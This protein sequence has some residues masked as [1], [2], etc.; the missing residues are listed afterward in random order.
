MK[1][2]LLSDLHI[3]FWPTAAKFHLAMFDSFQTDADVL[4]LAG[5]INVGRANTLSTLKEFAKRYKHVIYVMGNHEEYGQE[6]G[7]FWDYEKFV[8]KLPENVY[9][10]DVRDFI[11]VDGVF[12]FGSCLYTNFGNDPLAENMAR[13]GI[14][15][16]Q[17]IKGS[18]TADYIAE[19]ES[20][21]SG[22]KDCYNLASDY[23]KVIVTHF[24]PAMECISE[25]FHTGGN[26]GINKYYANNLGNY[27]A[28]LKDTTWLFGHTH[29]SIDMFIGDTRMLCNPMGYFGHEMN[30]NFNPKAKSLTFF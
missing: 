12:F 14:N 16:F 11:I 20:A 4:V 3:E 18:S 13:Y 25:R 7:A 27:I 6:F 22:I 21:I 15:D 24:L 5:D 17:R 30:P 28:E 19:Y 2:Q 10:L 23:K 1:I 26:S 8:S 29:D 9:F